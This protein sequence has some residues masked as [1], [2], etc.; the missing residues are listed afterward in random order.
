MLINTRGEECD[1]ILKYFETRCNT[2]MWKL[3]NTKKS[4][5][6]LSFSWKLSPVSPLYDF[7]NLEHCS[8]NPRLAPL[9]RYA[10]GHSS[11]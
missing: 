3:E 9:R 7:I 4:T 10:A 5:T 11:D 2:S 1:K 6:L 8:K